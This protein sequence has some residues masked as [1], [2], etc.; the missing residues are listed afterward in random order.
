[1]KEYVQ[2]HSYI[3]SSGLAN[4]IFVT[5]GIGF[6]F[7]T[8]AELIG[9]DSFIVTF[10]MLLG[11]ALKVFMTPALGAGIAIVEKADTLTVFSAM[12]AAAMGGGAIS[13]AET[14]GIEIIGGEPIG[15]LIAGTV[16]TFVGK[17]IKGNTKADMMLIPLCASLAG[18]IVGYGLSFIMSPIINTF[19]VTISNAVA[20]SPIVGSA[21]MSVL[22][23]L[24][25]MSPL[26]SAA[27]AIALQLSPMAS[28]AMLIGTTAQYFAFSICSSKE[29][30]FGGYIAQALCTPKVQ[31]GNVVKNPKIL[32]GPTISSLICAPIATVGFGFETIAEMGGM[33]FCSL[34]A[35]LNVLA[36]GGISQFIV[37]II[38]GA[39]LPVAITFAVNKVLYTKGAIKEGDMELVVV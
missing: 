30:D 34:V 17:R 29:N 1:M 2:K 28:G 14:G 19:S 5:V 27:L 23:G 38:F 15:A 31:L 8:L 6:L 21:V 9:G 33:G 10:L 12:A 20:G 16:A 37:Y 11:T 22:F 35:P 3:V 25:L 26:S 36:S 39:I 7:T 13:I 32:I 4:A 24:F 18:G